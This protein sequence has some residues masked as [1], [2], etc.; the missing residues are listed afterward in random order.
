[1]KE[2]R[3]NVRRLAR[4]KGKL[5]PFVKIIQR[6]ELIHKQKEKFIRMSLASN[7][8]SCQECQ[9]DV[10]NFLLNLPTPCLP[11]LPFQ[12]LIENTKSQASS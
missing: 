4:E 6:H 10:F 7:G 11:A 8:V 3:N 9:L 1:M 2:E 5:S 12:R